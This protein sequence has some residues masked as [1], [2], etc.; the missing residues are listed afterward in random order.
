[1]MLLQ[2]TQTYR[3]LGLSFEV[4]K[5]WEIVR[6]S[7]STERGRLVLVD[8]RRQRLEVCWSEC[9]KEPDLERLVEEFRGESA[10]PGEVFTRSGSWRGLS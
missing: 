8:R 5:E 1:M 9:K 6:H 2:P 3:W 4:P 10:L 7:T